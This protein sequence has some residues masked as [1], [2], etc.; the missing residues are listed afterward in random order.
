MAVD[1][2]VEEELQGTI[3]ST[4]T[5]GYIHDT[6]WNVYSLRC[7]FKHHDKLS[8]QKE[9]R[10]GREMKEITREDEG[11][12]RKVSSSVKPA[13]LASPFSSE[14][15]SKEKDFKDILAQNI[16]AFQ[17]G[18]RRK[19]LQILEACQHSRAGISEKDSRVAGECKCKE[20]DRHRRPH[21]DDSDLVTITFRANPKS[22]GFL[23][24][25]E[26]N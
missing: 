2:T 10:R 19:A 9:Q 15:Q 12:N 25:Y 4:Y 20:N 23:S 5:Q 7:K 17:L 24:L 13:H 21:T 3:T 26:L 1:L 16:G 6:V 22:P 18:D 8:T 14:S 11:R